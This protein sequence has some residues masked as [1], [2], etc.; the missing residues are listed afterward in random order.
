[1]NQSSVSTAIFLA[2]LL[3]LLMPSAVWL[4]MSKQR[5]RSVVYWCLGGLVFGLGAI[6][7]GLRGQAPPWVTFALANIGLIAGSLLQ[8][9]ALRIE[10]D[11]PLPS[12]QLAGWVL[13]LRCR[14]KFFVGCW[15]SMP[16]AFIGVPWHCS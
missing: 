10:L 9:Q 7:I 4:V 16:C 12:W 6:F 14:M 15:R 11:R 2:G 13:G 8:I 3:Y 5:T 1:M